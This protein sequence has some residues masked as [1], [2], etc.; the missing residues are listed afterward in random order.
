MSPGGGNCLDKFL[1]LKKSV[2]SAF[3]VIALVKV[4]MSVYLSVYIRPFVTF[5]YIVWTKLRHDFFTIGEREDCAWFRP[6]SRCI[7]ETVQ[8]RT[9]VAVDW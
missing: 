3:T 1:I 9:E 5:W 4:V 2:S 8:D 6:L 7:S